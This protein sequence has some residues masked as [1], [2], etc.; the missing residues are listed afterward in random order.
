[1]AIQ[2][3][4][5]DGETITFKSDKPV[6]VIASEIVAHDRFYE[7]VPEGKGSIYINPRQVASI[8]ETSDEPPPVAFEAFD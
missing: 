8:R 7:V 1:V 4:L 2:I 3:K 5:S 6:S